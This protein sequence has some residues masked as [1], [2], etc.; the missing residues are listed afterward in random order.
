MKDYAKVGNRKGKPAYLTPSR[1]IA[2]KSIKN[3][4]A[5]WRPWD[6]A[7]RL[8]HQRTRERRK[9]AS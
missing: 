6:Q 2:N 8:E 7:T 4:K 5:A 1:F 9:R 3:K